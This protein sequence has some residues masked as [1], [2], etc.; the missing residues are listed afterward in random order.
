MYSVPKSPPGQPLQPKAI[1]AAGLWVSGVVGSNEATGVRTAASESGYEFWP[2]PLGLDGSAPAN[3]ALFDRI[4]SLTKAQVRSYVNGGAEP[5][6][7]TDWPVGLGAPA[8]IDANG[9]AG[10]DEGE[11]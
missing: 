11:A 2:G 1:F 8:F 9:N 4:Y 3:C 10:F 7:L 6:D 5:A